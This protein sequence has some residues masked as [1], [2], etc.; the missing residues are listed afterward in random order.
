MDI[1]KKFKKQVKTKEKGR[2][3][4]EIVH[5]CYFSLSLQ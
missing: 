1:T 4:S 2:F 5:F 3:Y